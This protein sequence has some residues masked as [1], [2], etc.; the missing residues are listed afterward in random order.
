MTDFRRGELVT[1]KTGC[2]EYAWTTERS[3]CIIDEVLDD[4]D[5]MVTIVAHRD[6]TQ[7]VN[8][9]VEAQYFRHCTYAEFMEKYPSACLVSK[10]SVEE[11]MAI[12]NNGKGEKTKMAELRMD[13]V[14]YGAYELTTEERTALRT[15]IISLLEEYDYNPTTSAVDKIITE[16]VKNKG[17]MINLFKQ[18]PNYNGKYQISFDTDFTRSCD[19]E[20]ISNFRYY[21]QRVSD[22]ILTKEK[23]IGVF[24]YLEATQYY[25]RTTYIL[26]A[27]NSLRDNGYHVSEAED[28]RIRA[29]R[30]KWDNVIKAYQQAERDGLVYLSSYHSYDYELY[31]MKNNV[32]DF[33]TF[34][35]NERGNHIATEEFAERVNLWFPSVKAV[36]GQKISRIVNKV[37]KMAG[38]D[39][40]AEYNREFAKYSDAINPLTIKR[41][42]ILSCHPI[43]YFTMSFGNSWASCH[44]I[45]K[46]N[47]RNMP[48]DYSGCYSSGTMSY[49]LDGSSFVFYT[50]DKDY[51][52]NEYELQDKINRNMFHMGEDKLIQARIYPQATDG[53]NGIYKQ[54]REIV[55]NIIADCLDVPNMWKNVKGRSECR[56]VTSSYGTHY[57]DYCE[58]SD[59]NVSYLK[60][61][62]D[63]ININIIRIGHDPICP[64][65]GDTH[66]WQE[67]IECEGCYSNDKKCHNCGDYDDIDSMHYIDGEWYCEDCCF[68][69]EYHGEWE[70]GDRSEDSY[71]VDNYH[72]GARVCYEALENSGDFL[73]CEYCEEWFYKNNRDYIITED[74][75]EFCCV[76]CAMDGGYADTSD[77]EWYPEDEV[78]YCEYCDNHVH[79]DDWND[80]LKC[81]TDCED[82]VAEENAESESEREEE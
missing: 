69:C 52:G 71:Y 1:A 19:K 35:Y 58:F 41:H 11:L 62:D 78:H 63:Y 39:K 53:E 67:A 14:K 46:G 2:R 12:T 5:I 44:T 33:A 70:V 30:A 47:K 45:D 31:K 80:E 68:W 8:C 4:D 81:C 51:N 48:N 10:Y 40:D 61:D 64:N 17:W 32:Y 25:E 82:E 13:K 34:L 55:Q 21:L 74:G 6:G 20:V 75:T 42:T 3:L 77:G 60:G 27:F 66:D 23:N 59:C 22:R 72:Y 38:I 18:H 37:C 76:D 26:R 29:E 56:D 73:Y 43:D 16:W 54:F 65:C 28:K 49:M 9:I 79:N 50:V 7:G 24:T 15:E 36:A 57:R